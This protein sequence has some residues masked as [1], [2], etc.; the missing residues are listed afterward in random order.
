M[1]V[2]RDANGRFTT[3][4]GTKVGSRSA[5]KAKVAG[6][7][8]AV[9]DNKNAQHN[10][11]QVRKKA[12]K[13]DD[14]AWRKGDKEAMKKT[15][16]HLSKVGKG[17]DKLLDKQKALGQKSSTGGRKLLPFKKE[18]ANKKAQVKKRRARQ[19]KG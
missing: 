11:A 6:H 9:Q 15:E 4:G 5:K 3:S 10:L 8:K 17:M 16:A 14:R 19:G 18:V 12:E 1:P 2:K 13:D 7:K